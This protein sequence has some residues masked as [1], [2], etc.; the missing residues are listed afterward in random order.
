MEALK[1]EYTKKK[2]LKDKR[3]KEAHPL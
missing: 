3:K 2:T 1:S